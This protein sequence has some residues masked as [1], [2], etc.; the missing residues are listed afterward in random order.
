MAKSKLIAGRR[1]KSTVLV[2]VRT[3]QEAI[4]RANMA[5]ETLMESN[6]NDPS[7]EQI[8]NAVQHMS[9]I[10]KVNPQ[11]MKQDGV[12]S[13]SDYMDDAVKPEEARKLKNEVDM[14]LK[15]VKAQRSG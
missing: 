4:N 12:S 11:Q 1:K 15:I 14:I 6:P 2:S 5:V 13:I 8:E 9:R 3:I 7:I 10:L